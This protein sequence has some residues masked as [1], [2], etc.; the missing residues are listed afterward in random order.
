LEKINTHFI[1]CV[2]K[3]MHT[4]K[5]IQFSAKKAPEKEEK[6]K[7][8]SFRQFFLHRFACL[9]QLPKMVKQKKSELESE[10]KQ[11]LRAKEMI[12]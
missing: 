1:A 5:N 4:Q 12:V 9:L 10:E 7:R 6:E 2:S 11:L 3:E 8:I